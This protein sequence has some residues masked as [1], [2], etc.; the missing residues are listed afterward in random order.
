MLRHNLQEWAPNFNRAPTLFETIPRFPVLW[1]PIPESVTNFGTL[2]LR[3]C[4]VV[5][6]PLPQYCYGAHGPQGVLPHLPHLH[7]LPVPAP[8]PSNQNPPARHGI[9]ASH[10][11][12]LPPER[13]APRSR[14]ATPSTASKTISFQSDNTAR[15]RHQL[16]VLGQKSRERRFRW[17][18]RNVPYG[19]LYHQDLRCPS[20]PRK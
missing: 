2:G 6:R 10:P 15:P 16:G 4:W 17:R 9:G 14:L 1:A 3:V 5:S 13:S 7:L 19:S 12:I 20:D 8:P 18:G 11:A